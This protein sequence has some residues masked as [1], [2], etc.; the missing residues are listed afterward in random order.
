MPLVNY[1]EFLKMGEASYPVE[2][3][4][5]LKS[6]SSVRIKNGVVVLKLSRYAQGR[7]R[8]EIVEKFLKWAE[9]RLQKVKKLDFVNP[10]YEDGGRIVTHNKIYELTV[11]VLP[12]VISR[13]VL[14]EGHFLKIKLNSFLSEVDCEKKIK[15]LTEKAIIKDQTSYL[16]EVLQELNQ[17]HFQ[18]R[19][20]EIRFKRTNGRFGSCSS[21][22]NI[23]IAYRLLF[24]PREVFRYVC[25]H[26]LA[27]LKEFN[28]SARFWQWVENAMPNYRESEKWLKGNGFLLG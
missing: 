6:T 1:P 13:A 28:H 15:F 25:V 9:K 19:V 24:A 5:V 20:N 11:D 10:Q 17:L 21:K 18:E 7:K 14:R 26:E 16:I 8:D 27:H 3:R 4:A 2:Y 12:G 23:N 22:K